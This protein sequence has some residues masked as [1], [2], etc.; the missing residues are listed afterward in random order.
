[1][2]KVEVEVKQQQRSLYGPSKPQGLWETQDIT[3]QSEWWFLK[4]SME[5]YIVISWS[6]TQC[7]IKER[8]SLSFVFFLMFM[9]L[10]WGSLHG[11]KKSD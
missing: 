8:K 9:K 3:I 4:F 5:R 7:D 1:M 6:S 10:F 2:R 11:N